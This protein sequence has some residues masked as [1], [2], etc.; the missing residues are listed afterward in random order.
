MGYFGASLGPGEDFLN[1]LERES[2][3]ADTHA[4][5]IAAHSAQLEK[6]P[7]SR[8]RKCRRRA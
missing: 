3:R 2:D 4:G 5:A 1:S 6:V 8:V 7:R